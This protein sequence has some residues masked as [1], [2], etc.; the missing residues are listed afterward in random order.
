M[1]ESTILHVDM[2]AF[3]AFAK[4][5]NANAVF[6]WR[7]EY[8][9]AHINE[10]LLQP[11]IYSNTALMYMWNMYTSHYFKKMGANQWA[12]YNTLTDWSTHAPAARESSQVNIASI[13]YIREQ[14][15]REIVINNF[16]EAA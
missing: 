11:K 5:A 16:A 6:A 7:K 12:V 14:K 3:F 9:T 1:S 15:V 13:S 4:A 10:M 8:P 2:D